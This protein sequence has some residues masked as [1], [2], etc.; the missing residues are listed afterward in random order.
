MENEAANLIGF[1]ALAF[2]QV[3]A[4][5]AITQSG[6]MSNVC[7][8]AH[9]WANGAISSKY[10]IELFNENVLKAY[11]DNKIIPY[12]AGLVGL[13]NY[14]LM[15]YLGSEE[16]GTGIKVI[17]AMLNSAVIVGMYHSSKEMAGITRFISTVETEAVLREMKRQE[18][19][20]DGKKEENN[21]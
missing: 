14:L 11:N 21:E 18:I 13:I 20:V 6:R 12:R 15:I 9:H 16:I 8:N 1:L 2:L 3:V 19:N 7:Y 5:F 4:L 17:A 10:D